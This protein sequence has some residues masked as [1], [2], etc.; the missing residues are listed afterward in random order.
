MAEAMGLVGA[1]QTMNEMSQAIPPA[2][3]EHIGWQLRRYLDIGA[4]VRKAPR[5]AGDRERRAVGWGNG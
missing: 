1:G 4:K 3:A 2:Y 5:R